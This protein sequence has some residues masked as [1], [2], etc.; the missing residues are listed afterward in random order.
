MLSDTWDDAY[1][2]VAERLEFDEPYEVSRAKVKQVIIELI[3]AGNP[4][5]AEP[6]AKDEYCD[7]SETSKKQFSYIRDLCR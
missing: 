7:D 1:A 4:H 6:S 5:K 3:G 2:V